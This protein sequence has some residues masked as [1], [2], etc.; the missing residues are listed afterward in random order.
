VKVFGRPASPDDAALLAPLNAQLIRD[1]GHRNAMSV[2]ELEQRMRT[3]LQSDYCAAIFELDAKVVGYA[4]FKHEAEHVYL[5]QLFVSSEFRRRGVG[6][7]MLHW[8][9]A[10]TWKKDQRLRVDVLINN[11]D[12]QAFW[13]AVGLKDYCVMLEMERPKP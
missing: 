10:N 12:A 4:L 13:R 9:W 8:L 5:R 6:R 11:T 7:A 2:G 3:W 1:E